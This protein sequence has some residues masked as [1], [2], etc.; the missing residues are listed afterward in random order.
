MDS[1]LR[2]WPHL[3]KQTWN[4]TLFS[5]NNLGNTTNQRIMRLQDPKSCSKFSALGSGMSTEGLDANVQTFKDS[6]QCTCMT[7]CRNL[8]NREV[9]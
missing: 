9:Q 8:I 7:L 5:P 2:A 1:Q 3:S 4:G 6:E